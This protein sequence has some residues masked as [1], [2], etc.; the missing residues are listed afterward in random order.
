MLPEDGLSISDNKF[1]NVDF[2]DPEGPTK[3][4]IFPFLNAKLSL[5]NI[6]IFL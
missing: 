6:L 3:E 2:P 4:Y 5:F 1:N